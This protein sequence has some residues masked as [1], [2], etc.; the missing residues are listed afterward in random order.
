MGDR[1]QVPGWSQRAV[2][3]A[4]ALAAALGGL[5]QEQ[6]FKFW[7]EEQA[8]N[9][10]ANEE[11]ERRANVE[12]LLS[13]PC[14]DRIKN[15]KIL[16]LIGEDQNGFIMARQAAYSAPFDA[17]NRRLR[18]LGVRNPPCVAGRSPR[19]RKSTLNAY[20]MRQL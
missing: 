12:A 8:E 11:F 9:D 2:V 7:N 13:T 1:G 3:A 15:Q 14:R 20:K 18:W 16:V 19:P 10:R 17:I 5:A 4:F 6:D